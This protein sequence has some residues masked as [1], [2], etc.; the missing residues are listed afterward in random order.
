MFGLLVTTLSSFVQEEE[1][2]VDSY[3]RIQVGSVVTRG[4]DWSWKNQ[5]GGGKGVVLAIVRWKN[6]PSPR[7]YAVKVKWDATGDVNVYRYGAEDKVDISIVGYRDVN[8]EENKAINRD[9]AAERNALLR[10]YRA[11]NGEYWYSNKGWSENETVLCNAE[12]TSSWDGVVCNIEGNVVGLDISSNN[13]EGKLASDSFLSLNSLESLTIANNRIFGT[14]PNLSTM[15][16]I[17]FLAMHNNQMTGT[18]PLEIGRLSQLEW[19]S[20]YNNRFTGTIPRTLGR[21]NHLAAMFLQTNR[22]TGTI[23]LEIRDMNSLRDL[24]LRQNRLTG[25]LPILDK[26]V[27]VRVDDDLG[28]G[29]RR[30]T[31]RHDRISALYRNKRRKKNS[32]NRNDSRCVEDGG[33][34]LVNVSDGVVDLNAIKKDQP[35]N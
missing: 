19:L 12:L 31:T 26:R 20:L 35:T 6:D 9:Y 11:A 13:A 32:P 21:L 28:L 15:K 34:C 8:V 3:D 4:P 5:D 18:M 17:R 14:I 2:K 24:D 10:I 23:P 29:K 30:H 16:D 27:R 33:T 25:T 22:L 1:K 7:K